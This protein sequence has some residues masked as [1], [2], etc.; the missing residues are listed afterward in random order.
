MP[1]ADI[2]SFQPTL[3]FLPV[4]F[5]VG[6]YL[7]VTRWVPRLLCTLK[8]RHWL[9]GV[10]HA[11][12]AGLV[13]PV[14]WPEVFLVFV[15]FAGLVYFLSRLT[16]VEGGTPGLTPLRYTPPPARTFARAGGAAVENFF[17]LWGHHRGS[18]LFTPAAAE[19]SVVVD[20][21]LGGFTF[22]TPGKVFPLLGLVLRRELPRGV[23]G[24]TRPAG[25]TT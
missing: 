19:L 2:L 13:A 25:S 12:A 24:S 23:S 1:Q 6:Y 10:T 21:V 3:L 17:F 15:Q 9:T 7:F 5:L 16:L 14:E 4:S 20:R 8:A 22:F 18:F 11:G